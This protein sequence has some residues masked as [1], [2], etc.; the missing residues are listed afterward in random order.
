MLDSRSLPKYRFSTRARY[1]NYGAK[2]QISNI[3]NHENDILTCLNT[4]TCQVL[5]AST[6]V[7][8]GQQAPQYHIQ[9]RHSIHPT[10]LYICQIQKKIL[11][12]RQMLAV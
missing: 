2:M 10:H 12:K 7:V 8:L 3:C 4:N 1:L 6:V 5:V 11:Q 9:V